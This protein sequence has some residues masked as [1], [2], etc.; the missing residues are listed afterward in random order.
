MRKYFSCF[1]ICILVLIVSCDEITHSVRIKNETTKTIEVKVNGRTYGNIKPGNTT[2]YETFR[3]NNAFY[4][5]KIFDLEIT[6]PEVS[7]AYGD[8]QFGVQEYFG[9]V[10]TEGFHIGNTKYSLRVFP[11]KDNSLDVEL[12]QD[13]DED[14][15][16]S[17]FT[18]Y[19]D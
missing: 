10:Y 5:K 15:D 12:T 11:K 17:D 13:N 3:K 14:E 1:A 8:V 7:F 4:G 19:D 18:E 16:Y 9:Y 2:S 6:H